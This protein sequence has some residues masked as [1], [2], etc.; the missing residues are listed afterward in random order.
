M[1]FPS[2]F[3]ARKDFITQNEYI[4]PKLLYV[5]QMLPILFPKKVIKEMNSWI[6]FFK[7]LMGKTLYEPG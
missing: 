4:L 6:S 5:C 2:A 7:F 1:D 3:Y